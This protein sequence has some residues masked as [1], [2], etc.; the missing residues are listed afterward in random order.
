MKLEDLTGNGL[1]ALFCIGIND[2]F[3]RAS[4]EE[5]KVVGGALKEA[6]DDLEGRFG[7]K[8]LGT[9]DDDLLQCGVGHDYPY[10]SYILADIPD[11]EAAV[12]VTNQ[13]R[14]KAGESLLSRYVTIQ[15][16]IGHPLFFGTK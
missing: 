16:R 14:E 5:K 8:V 9:L 6:F 1:R 4:G 2:D 15:T 3:F 12:A 7:V 13:V 10:I 11:F